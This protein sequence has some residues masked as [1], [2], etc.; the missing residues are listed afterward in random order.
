MGAGPSGFGASSTAEQVARDI[1]LAGKNVIV[2]GGN[3]GE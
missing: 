1:S 2:T 3:T